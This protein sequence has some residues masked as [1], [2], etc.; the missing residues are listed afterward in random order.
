MSYFFQKSKKEQKKI[1]QELRFRE[2]FETKKSE[3]LLE[4][5][6]SQLLLAEYQ[7]R[8]DKEKK[9]SEEMEEVV[10]RKIYRKDK[11]DDEYALNWTNKEWLKTLKIKL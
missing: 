3:T 11:I 5:Q 2:C 10:I 7:E 9:E 4:I 8:L 1:S 6:R